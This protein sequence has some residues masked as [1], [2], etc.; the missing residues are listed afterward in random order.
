MFL[1]EFDGAVGDTTILANRS[2]Y[3]DF[4]LPYSET[5]IVVV[6]PVKDEREKGKWVFLKPL[7]RELWF[8]TAASFLYIGIMVWIFEYQASGDFRKQSIINKISNVFYFSFSTLFFAHSEL[9]SVTH[10][11]S[12]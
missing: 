4:A 6:V 8:L 2:T 7:T 10:N 9:I 5:G 1:Q 12:Y 3:V 11:F